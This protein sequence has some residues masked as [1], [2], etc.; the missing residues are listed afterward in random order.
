MDV[1]DEL[2]AIARLKRGDIGG[3]ELLVRQYHARAV[4]CPYLVVHD[5]ALA[6][7]IAQSSFV[8]AFERIEQFDMYRPFAPWFFKLVLREVQRP[9]RPLQFL[10][11]LLQQ[12]LRHAAQYIDVLRRIRR[13]LAGPVARDWERPVAARCR[14]S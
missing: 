3:L 8:R 7:D 9:R 6:L 10:G 2:S 12:H 1:D 14:S 4:R 5:H 11:G 13:L